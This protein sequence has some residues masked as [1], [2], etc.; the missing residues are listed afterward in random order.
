MSSI[1]KLR[2]P[3]WSDITYFILMIVVPMVIAFIEIFQSHSTIFKITF[4]SIA[5]ILLAILVIRRFV[6]KGKIKDFQEKC[7]LLEHDY[8]NNIGSKEN[9]E[10]QW[11]RYQ[12]IMYVYNAIVIL[13]AMILS[14]LF[15]TALSEQLIAFRGA[16]I[17]IF[18]SVLTAII[19]K[20]V[21]HVAYIKKS[22]STK[23]INNEK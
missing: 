20:I 2:L 18:A 13:L 14:V 10:I 23:E 11:H 17:I 8:S 21:L 16:S 12:L 3:L 15:I 1:P 6:L 7:V 9:E 4:S 5:T 22:S 19:F